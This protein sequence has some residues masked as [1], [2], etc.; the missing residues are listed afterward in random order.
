MTTY[1]TKA[2]V[3]T[4]LTLFLGI[5]G[6]SPGYALTFSEVQKLL[7]SDGA[8]GDFFGN[9]ISISGD[10]AVIGAQFDDDDNGT[11]SGSVYVFMRDGAGVLH[12]QQKLIAS[13][14]AAFDSFGSSVSLSGDTVFINGSGSVY[15]FVRDGTG[16]WSEQQ[17]LTTVMTLV[18]YRSPGIQ[19]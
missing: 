7:A 8:S 11:R 12:E 2:L 13:D 16:T 6:V 15:V 9:S 4:L 10:T 14:G 1:T 3:L 17:K 5:F 18:R 19:P